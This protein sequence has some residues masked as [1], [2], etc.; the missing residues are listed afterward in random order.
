MYKKGDR[1]KYVGTFKNSRFIDD[2]RDNNHIFEVLDR[3]YDEWGDDVIIIKSKHN[4]IRTDKER[5]M[6]NERYW[7]LESRDF[8]K[9]KYFFNFDGMIDD[10]LKGI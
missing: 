2:C 10:I 6:V 9:V 5:N 4:E 3:Y 1:V 8:V 7:K